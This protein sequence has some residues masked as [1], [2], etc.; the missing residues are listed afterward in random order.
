MAHTERFG[1]CC[2]TAIKPRRGKHGRHVK[3]GGKMPV[4][5]ERVLNAHIVRKCIAIG[6]EAAGEAQTGVRD[7]IPDALGI[8]TVE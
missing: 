6:R 8:I 2:R 1:I 4:D 7:E 3:V 5:T